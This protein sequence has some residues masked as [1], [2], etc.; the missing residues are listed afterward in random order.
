M[1][2]AL[3]RVYSA[4]AEEKLG[5][6]FLVFPQAP[7]VTGY[8]KPET[9]WIST[10]PHLILPGP[11]D[12]RM[13]VRDPLQAKAA[14]EFPHLPPYVGDVWPPVQ[15]GPDGHY[16]H[17]DPNSREFVSAHIFA[18]LHRVLD[19]WDGYLGH[20]IG[21][22]FADVYERLEII[23]QIDWFNAHSGFGYM[24][25]GIDDTLVDHPVPFGLNFDVIAHE[26]GHLIML[27]EIGVPGP[28]EP[29]VG[30]FG[31]HESISDI[32]AM[33]SFLHFDSAVERL[34]RGTNGNL[35]V[36][37]ELNRI[38]EISTDTQF[39]TASNDRKMSSVTRELH[40]MSTPFTGAIFDT[41]IEIY[42]EKV[43]QRNL[44]DLPLPVSYDRLFELDADEIEDIGDRFAEVFD[45]R[46]VMFKSALDDARDVLGS[47]IA[48]SWRNLEP[49]TLTFGDGG[50]AIA[51]ELVDAGEPHAADI[52]VENLHLAGDYIV[53]IR[54]KHYI[55]R[56]N[57]TDITGLLDY[58]KPSFP[59]D[60]G[61]VI[62]VGYTLEVEG[63]S[64]T[65][66]AILKFD[67]NVLEYIQL[68]INAQK[69]L[70]SGKFAD[71]DATLAYPKMPYIALIQAYVFEGNVYKLPKSKLMILDKNA[72]E[73]PSP[74]D[75]TAEQMPKCWRIN[76]L[77]RAVEVVVDTGLI[78]Q[79]VLEA[80][81]PGKR[82]P[83]S[84]AANF[85]MANRSSR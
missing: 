64:N 34:L 7:H 60:P 10:P 58:L 65:N 4:T 16:D 32:I 30:F 5:T 2:V 67:L 61:E 85:Q 80:N 74:T 77:E 13:Y 52:L 31:Y 69:A 21:W 6:R 29:P 53:Y 23:P 55:R 38:A 44:I 56:S 68:T 63:T 20:R 41:L 45:T 81:L 46:Q 71:P 33:L 39:R 26:L 11:Q 50:M 76:K 28:D 42:H 75:V 3:E 24:E 79:L 19:I 49:M 66:Q 35:L 70:N 47:A 37:N 12:S 36:L 22:H 15:P 14:Y 18:C 83:N 17:L 8:A 82:S 40:D 9:I 62:L 51:D 57:V 73:I 27:A 48:R 54:S 43:V 59:Y 84:Y 1:S 78:E 25:F 72:E